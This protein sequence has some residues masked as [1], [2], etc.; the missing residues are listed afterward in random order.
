MLLLN[1]MDVTQMQL[2]ADMNN[3]LYP[4]CGDTD[5]TV[6]AAFMEA[7]ERDGRGLSRLE[8]DCGFGHPRLANI[9]YPSRQ[10][11]IGTVLI[12]FMEP[13]YDITLTKREGGK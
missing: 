1:V 11:G 3:R 9:K 10:P 8:I 6:R 13:G 7:V 2:K 5:E 4:E 12:A